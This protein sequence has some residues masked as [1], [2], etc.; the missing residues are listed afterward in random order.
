MNMNVQAGVSQGGPVADRQ[1]DSPS[2][3]VEVPTVSASGVPTSGAVAGAG[4]AAAVAG[5]VKK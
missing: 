3:A 4:G 5:S 2:D 1:V